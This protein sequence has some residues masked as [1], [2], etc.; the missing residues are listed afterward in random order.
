MKRAL[1]TMG[2]LLAWA[3]LC[4]AQGQGGPKV[5]LMIAEQ[6]IGGHYHYWWGS[7]AEEVN[8][9][10]VEMTLI[11][12]LR[13]AGFEV[14]D[15]TAHEL[16]VDK[17]YRHLDLTPPEALRLG[18]TYGA[19]LVVVGKALATKGARLLSTSMVSCTATI[20]AKVVDVRRHRVVAYLSAG[21]E[22]VHPDPIAGGQE[23]LQQAARELA[24]KL[25]AELQQ[26][27]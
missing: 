9:S 6:S 20:N 3:L 21:G 18:K 25:I 17:P 22:S 7:V 10:T 2:G 5:L 16:K 24:D 23:A 12:A 14:V 27:R 4:G 15:P 11:P 26:G 19:D 1:R 8:L 13:R